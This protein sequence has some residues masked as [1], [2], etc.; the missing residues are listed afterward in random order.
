MNE[1]QSHVFRE[2]SDNEMENSVVDALRSV[3]DPEIP[4]NI[5]DLGLIYEIAIS[6]SNKIEIIMTLTSPFCP[7][8]E[9][10]MEDIYLSVGNLP[11]ANGVNVEITFDPPWSPESIPDEVK[12]ELG[13]L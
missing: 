10:I 6:T 9:Q 5:Y 7:A 3:Y 13:M 8:T 2:R 1:F 12:F 11:D 4:V